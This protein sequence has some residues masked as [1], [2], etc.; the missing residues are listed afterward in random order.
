MKDIRCMLGSHHFG[1]W[2][3]VES[4]LERRCLRCGE[5][6]VKYPDPLVLLVKMGLTYLWYSEFH[7][8]YGTLP[9]PIGGWKDNR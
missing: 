7:R 1:D 4:H 2:I 8:K 3:E 9:P 5:T 6:E